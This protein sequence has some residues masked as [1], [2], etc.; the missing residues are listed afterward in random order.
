LHTT[1]RTRFFDQLNVISRNDT[2][3]SIF[4][5]ITPNDIAQIN[6]LPSPYSNAFNEELN[7]CQFDFNK[8]RAA[9]LSLIQQGDWV[10]LGSMV[11]STP[12]A[13]TPQEHKQLRSAWLI[14]INDIMVTTI[15]DVH[16]IIRTLHQDNV[17]TCILLFAHPKMKHGSIN[18]GITLL[19]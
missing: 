11:P 12:G 5:S 3:M 8:H 17:T 14:S 13:K 6:M 2:K 1:K 7:L 16:N 9:A 10:F 19:Q 15:T 18:K 4:Y